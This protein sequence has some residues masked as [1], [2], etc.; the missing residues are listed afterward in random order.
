MCAHLFVHKKYTQNTHIICK[1]KSFILYMI[2]RLTTL[3]CK[4]INAHNHFTWCYCRSRTNTEIR[5]IKPPELIAP[6]LF[7]P[8]IY[9]LTKSI[10]ILILSPTHPH[11]TFA[12][13]TVSNI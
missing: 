9:V 11:I 4:R 6:L 3:R 2:N 8:P 5:I 13:M 7:F 12:I 1:Y 10:W